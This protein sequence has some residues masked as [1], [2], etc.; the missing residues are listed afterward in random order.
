MRK[1]RKITKQLF[2][3]TMVAFLGVATVPVSTYANGVDVVES[4]DDILNIPDPEL[5]KVLNGML[6]ADRGATQDITRGDLDNI[7]NKN[8]Q[9]LYIPD[10][11]NIKS[12]AGLDALKSTS[13]EVIYF[14]NMAITEADCLKEVTSESLAN[15]TINNS[16]LNKVFDISKLSKLELLD[17][18][19]NKIISENLQGLGSSNTLKNLYLAGNEIKSLKGIE[20]LTGLINL[21]FDDQ[22]IIDFDEVD[23]LLNKLPVLKNVNGKNWT[24]KYDR[25]TQTTPGDGTQLPEEGTNGDQGGNNSDTGVD[26][27]QGNQNPDTGA[28][29]DQGNPNPD[30]GVDGDQ[31]NL[32]P[33]TGA[34]EGQ[35]TPEGGQE[36]GGSQGKPEGGQE[37]SGD[38]SKPENGN[39]DQNQGNNDKKDVIVFKD[40]NL[41]KAVNGL[42]N[43]T[44]L[45]QDVEKS[46]VLY[47]DKVFLSGKQIG[48]ITGLDAFVSVLDLDLSNNTIKD[49]KLLETMTSVGSINLSNNQVEKV[50]D[51][52]NLSK[53]DGLDL[54][55]NNITSLT[56]IG[57]STT[58][59]TL[60]LQGNKII[61]LVGIENLT[62][63][64]TLSFDD[65][66][67]TDFDA[68]NKSLS[69]LKNLENVN[70]KKWTGK[71][72]NPNAGN[73]GNGG[74]SSNTG[75]SG[76]SGGVFVPVGG[77]S[78]PSTEN[79]VEQKEETKLEE[80]KKPE[81]E[82]KKPAVSSKKP[83]VTSKKP[84]VKNNSAAKKSTTASKKQAPVI[85][86][87][88][89]AVVKKATVTAKATTLNLAGN[90][91]TKVEVKVK[92][93]YTVKY[94][95]TS[96]NVTVDKKTG[97]VTAKKSGVAT[98]KANIYK[99]GKFVGTKTLKIT[100]KNTAKKKATK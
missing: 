34:G 43:R 42:L 11:Q 79:K 21:T 19:N 63:L 44:D 71:Y 94:T 29:G 30:T 96:K 47:T 93:G 2:A 36:N 40:E 72:E 56:G 35:G 23:Q 9:Y 97:K 8:R 67:I 89:A 84:A 59:K 82:N 54:Q 5:K 57:S 92:K 49:A 69:Q 91:T 73:G 6:G 4:M 1:I 50:F 41:K 61:S 52:S 46:D 99:N 81:V 48:D 14:D 80:N 74:A 83:A 16:N 64:T 87:A 45:Q 78:T 17:L 31:G 95:T 58:L 18:A 32:N 12:L 13:I 20:N 51:I 53:L 98:I 90:K 62:G 75:N 39:Q 3:L 60:L 65:S 85:S 15:I 66:N 37:N 22:Y 25:P 68:L 77:G 33:D 26:G 10:N 88:D 86:K 7:V 55:N 76:S 38:Q 100:I 70:G 24:G 27:D 28:D